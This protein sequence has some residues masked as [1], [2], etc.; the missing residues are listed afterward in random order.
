MS[1]LGSDAE[2]QLNAA[3]M[4]KGD[5]QQPAQELPLQPFFQWP[6]KA[7]ENDHGI[8]SI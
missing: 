3:S 4:P 8:L 6:I 1:V 5:C 7:E 2:R